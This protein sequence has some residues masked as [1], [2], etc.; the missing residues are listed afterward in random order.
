MS[1]LSSVDSLSDAV[2]APRARKPRSRFFTY[3]RRIQLWGFSFVLPTLMFLAVFKY[4][5]MLWAIDLSFHAYDMVSPPRYIG[6]DNYRTLF[7]DPVFR[8]TLLN[9]IVYITG[10]T[11]L[12]MVVD[13]ASRSRSTPAFRAPATAWR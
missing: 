9:T 7:A 8:E 10:S 2:P 4:G 6:L 5:P 12:T 3:R 13:S 11:V 1:G